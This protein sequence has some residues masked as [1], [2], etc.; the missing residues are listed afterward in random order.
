MS[1]F[2]CQLDQIRV[3]APCHVDW[4]SMFGNERIR[5][6]GQCQLNVY[7]LSEL[8]RAEAEALI[9]RTEGRLCVRYY[10]RFDGSIITR[11]CPIGM[12]A[13]KRRLS[14]IATAVASAVLSFFAGLGVYGIANSLSLVSSTPSSVMGQIAIETPMQRPPQDIPKVA[15]ER[16]RVD[17]IAVVGRLAAVKIA[18][19]GHKLQRSRSR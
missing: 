12:K 19:P 13:I 4:D 18:D 15:V 2:N 7:N 11:N 8:T 6:C 16:P 1:R 10:Q 14:R 9:S 3:A 17:E 5:F